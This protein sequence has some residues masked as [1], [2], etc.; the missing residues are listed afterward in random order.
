MDLEICIDSVE[1]AI[2]AEKGGAQ[3]VELCSALD[4]GGLTPSAGLLRT[5][6]SRV[7]IGVYVMIRPRGGDFLYSAEELTVMREDIAFAASCG[8]QGV[9]FGLLTADGNVDI[10]AARA[11]VQLAAPMEVTFHRAID[12][13][14][15]PVAS[16]EDVIRTGARRILT[17][18]AE[19]TAQ[20]GIPRIAQMMKIAKG[21]IGVMV[22]GS[23]RAENVQEIAHA[24]RASEFHAALRNPVPSP[25]V[26]QNHTLHLGSPDS[27]EYGRQVVLVEDVRN[28][29]QAMETAVVDREAAH[30]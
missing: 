10:E 29:R 27:D 3:R 20:Q 4:E 13:S 16:V 30:I 17:S 1:S 7:G 24:T 22:C 9:V 25:V 6:R 26:Y 14:R 21:R 11:L 23:V 15:D 5:V 12:M 8:A 18:G 2:A 28:L 19:A